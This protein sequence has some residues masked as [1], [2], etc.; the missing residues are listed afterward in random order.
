ML[1]PDAFDPGFFRDDDDPS[2][3]NVNERVHWS[4]LEKAVDPAY[5]PRNLPTNLAVGR[6]AAMTAE[7]ARWLGRKLVP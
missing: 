7:E 2:R 1:S 3:E 4:V 6:V 5:A